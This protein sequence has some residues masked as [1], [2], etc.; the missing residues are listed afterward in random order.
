R[1]A[2]LGERTVG[3]HRAHGA[4]KLAHQQEELDGEH[5]QLF[6]AQLAVGELEPERVTTEGP[7]GLDARYHVPDELLPGHNLGHRFLLAAA[8]SGLMVLLSE[9][10][11]ML[12]VRPGLPIPRAVERPHSPPDREELALRIHLAR[13]AMAQLIEKR[14]LETVG[15]EHAGVSQNER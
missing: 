5:L 1:D 2:L 4:G 6:A 3:M 12:S 8:V 10:E 9:V 11:S 13:D 14:A 7:A 15:E